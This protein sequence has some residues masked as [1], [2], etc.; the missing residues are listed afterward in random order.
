MEITR[1]DFTESFILLKVNGLYKEGMSTEEIYDI[2]RGWWCVN[3]ERAAKIRYAAAVVSNIIVGVFEID[4]WMPATEK[5]RGISEKLNKK[6]YGFNGRVAGE[7]IR[8]KY[9]GKSVSGLYK[10]GNQNPVMYIEP[11]DR[12]GQK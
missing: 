8:E 1:E 2:T 3:P 7:E 10:R 12:Q 6:R 11:V 9:V 4:S 5:D